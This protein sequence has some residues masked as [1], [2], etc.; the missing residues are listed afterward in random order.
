MSLSNKGRSNRTAAVGV[1]VLSVAMLSTCGGGS[2]D[3][4]TVQNRAPSFDAESYVF[5]VPENDG[6]VAGA[7]EAVDLDGDNLALTLTGPDA[8]IFTIDI[9]GQIVFLQAPDFEAPSDSNADNRYDV[10]V[11]AS[12]GALS[13]SVNVRVDVVNDVSDDENVQRRLFGLA[14]L[15]GDV[16]TPDYD[17]PSTWDD[18]DGDCISDRHE[19][20][21]AQHLD[22]DGAYPL[23]MSTNGCAVETGRWLD[24][25]DN[26]YY[27]AASNVQIDHVVALYESWV[28][29]LGNLISSLQRRYANTGSLTEG[30][31]PET[32]H[33]FLAVGASSNGEKGGS[34]PREWMPR[35]EAYHCTYLKKWVL[36]KSQNELLFDQAEFDFIQAREVDCGDEPLPELPAN[37]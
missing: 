7:V 27:Y 30:V 19:V 15:V 4:P 21:I 31:L 20:L 8:G 32:S 10:V 26:I 36:T 34:D 12:D 9:R 33:N 3:S 37:P 24:P 16:S 6:V 22:G 1:A 2:G 28:S 17:R 18:E 25:Y 29:G 13:R 14:V 35:N 5:T 23:V 11:T